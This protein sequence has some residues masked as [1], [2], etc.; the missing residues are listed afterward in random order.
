MIYAIG[1]RSRRRRTGLRAW[2]RRVCAQPSST[3]CRIRASRASPR[4]PAA[5]RGNQA[6]RRS[7]KAFAYVADELHGQY[8]LGFA[9]P[10]RDGKVHDIDVRVA[11]KGLKPRAR[12][13]YV[14]PKG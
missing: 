12:K 6:R 11:T 4:R 9:P 7:A 1:L 8:L 10:Q 5:A 2:G 13:S 3:I 14:A